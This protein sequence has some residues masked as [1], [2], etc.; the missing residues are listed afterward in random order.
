MKKLFAFG[1]MFIAICTNA[2]AETNSI[3][4]IEGSISQ[5]KI[6]TATLY[7]A[8]DG[9]MVEWGSSKVNDGQF[10]FALI[11]PEEGFYYV[12]DSRKNSKFLHYRFYIKA[13]EKINLKIG[14]ESYT[15]EG[16]SPENKLLNDWQQVYSEIYY[17]AYEFW[18]DRTG[19]VTYFPLF[20]SFLPKVKVFKEKIKSKDKAFVDFYSFLI[21]NDVEAAALRFLLTPRVAQPSKEEYIPYYNNIVKK[22][23]YCTTTIMKLGDG[24]NRLYTYASFN[25]M[26]NRK[27]GEDSN[28]FQV[29]INSICNDT[30]KGYFF[31][32]GLARYKT[33]DAL[34]LFAAPYKKYLV[35]E[36]L[37]EDYNNA[38]SNVATF[39]KGEKAFAFSYPDKNDR[40]VTLASLKGKVVLIDTWATWCGPCKAE[41]PHLKKLEEE[42]K[43]EPIAIVSISLDEKKDEEKWKTFIDKEHLGGIQLFAGGFDSEFAKY[44][45]INAIPRFLIFDKEGNIVTA[46]AP[47]PSDPILKDLLLKLTKGS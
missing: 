9:A 20:E 2:L 25:Y 1:V 18:N 33:Y 21:D 29:G 40:Q 35:T 46:D 41:I 24:L 42:V 23:K 14:E 8:V 5:E 17:P 7:R 15:I 22:D 31:I 12:G 37:N 39:K 16:N 27:E 32:N 10:A 30:L 26:K 6:P 28:Y 34:E 4:T 36:T 13:G 3:V 38:L 11:N 19:Y 44:Y 43:G 45:K 47:R